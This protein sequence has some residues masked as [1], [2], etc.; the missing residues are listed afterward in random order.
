V[1]LLFGGQA[2]HSFGLSEASKV[3][4]PHL[5]QFPASL[6]IPEPVWYFPGP[7]SRQE[8]DEIWAASSW[9]LPAPHNVQLAEPGMP[10]PVWYV[11]ARQSSQLTSSCLPLPV[12]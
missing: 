12:W 10:L 3:P 1:E 5:V 8:A 9:Y 11:P 6:G 2:E 4:A 7:Q